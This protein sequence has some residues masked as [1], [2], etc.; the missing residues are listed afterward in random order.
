MSDPEKFPASATETAEDSIAA[1]LLD[2]EPPETSLPVDPPRSMAVRR[3]NVARGTRRHLRAIRLVL[4][5]LLLLALMYTI[6]I[7]KA[8]LIPLVLAAFIGLALNPIVA[9]GTRISLPRWLTASVLMIGLVIGIGTG[10]GLLAQ[11]AIGWFHGAPTA[12]RSF[13]PKFRNLTKPLEAANRATQTLVSGTTRA[14]TPTATPI[15]ITAW[16]VVSTAPKILAA[17]LSVMLLVF[18]FLVYGDSMLRRLVEIT[19]SFA[20]KRHAVTIVRGIQ[21]EVSRY[22]LTASLIN[23]SLGAT[24]AAMLWLYKVPDPLLWGAVAMFAN[25]IPYVGAIVTT[26]LLAVVCMLYANNANLEVFLPVLT[27]AGITAVEG[28]LITPLIQGASMRLSPIAI[29]LW[30]LVWGWLWGI[31]GALLA[32]PMLTCTKLVTER[33][34]GWEWFA[35]IVQR[36]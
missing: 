14:V 24:T 22:L 7:T 5:A 20:Y 21:T 34:H 6:T 12:I 18:F 26:T 8:L 11:P 2:P 35:H 31:P 27:F 25:F 4:N 23:V 33:V 13:V 16:D 30:L 32:V 17:V 19:P 15:S 10:V 9:A 36:G 3:L 29:L 1:I 28:N